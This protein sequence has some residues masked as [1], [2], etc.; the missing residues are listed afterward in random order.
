MLVVVGSLPYRQVEGVRDTG[1]SRG[2]AAFIMISYI[3]LVHYIVSLSM[4]TA[5]QLLETA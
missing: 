1:D 5:I 3:F 4:S 2:Q